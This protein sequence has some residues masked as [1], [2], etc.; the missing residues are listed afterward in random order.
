MKGMTDSEPR[1]SDKYFDDVFEY[2]HVT[3]PEHIGKKVNGPVKYIWEHHLTIFQ[4]LWA[5]TIGA[6]GF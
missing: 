3:L 1:Y 5:W 4:R 2:R 6:W